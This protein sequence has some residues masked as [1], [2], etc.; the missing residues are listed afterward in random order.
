MET[1]IMIAFIV[2]IWPVF[3]LILIIA[4]IYSIIISQHNSN[5]TQQN[6]H[7]QYNQNNTIRLDSGSQLTYSGDTRYINGH[8]LRDHEDW[9]R[10][11][12]LKGHA[13][14][15]EAHV[16]SLE[17]RC[18]DFETLDA[19]QKY[20]EWEKAYNNYRDFCARYMLWNWFI[21]DRQIFKPTSSQ[22]I[23]ENKYK[24]DVKR[25]FEESILLRELYIDKLYQQEVRQMKILDY[26][27]KCPRKRA[28]R[29]EMLKELSNKGERS[30]VQ[31]AYND[32]LK[33]GIIGEKKEETHYLVRI[34]HRRKK[35]KAEQD[36]LQ[37]S[38]YKPSLYD[39]VE[40]RTLYKIEYTVGLPQNIDKEKNVCQFISTTTGELYNTSLEFCSCPVYDPKHPC[41]HMVALATHLGYFDSRMIKN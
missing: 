27:D 26:I 4:I 29:H 20:F 7:P 31:T 13:S 6:I 36:I 22:S 32:L 10:W 2:K 14:A 3:V 34:I 33:R 41:K 24:E 38:V 30:L 40:R 28:I 1:I 25:K 23:K 9:E 16:S 5:N 15:L 18:T 39:H 8:P 12:V 21:G 35:R 37:Q 17:D 11:S 19:E